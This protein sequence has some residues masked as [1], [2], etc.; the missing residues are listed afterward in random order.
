VLK[1]SF[2]V[3]RR[4]SVCTESIEVTNPGIFLTSIEVFSVHGEALES[5]R[6]FF[7]NLPES[8]MGHFQFRDVGPID[9]RTGRRASSHWIRLVD[10]PPRERSRP[11]TRKRGIRSMASMARLKRVGLIADGELQRRVDVALLFV[12]A[13]MDIVLT[14]PAVDEAMDQPRVSMEVEDHGLVPG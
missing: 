4:C 10:Q 12:A 7:F 13:H 8:K 5:F 11:V 2:G 9:G 3:L 14:G 6:T 1:N